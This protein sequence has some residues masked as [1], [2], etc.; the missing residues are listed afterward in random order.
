VL[1]AAVVVLIDQLTKLL[2]L[3]YLGAQGGIH[4][5]GNWLVL[6]VG[7]NTGAAFS[8]LTGH[9]P[10]FVVIA[11]AA[12]VVMA[13][14]YSRTSWRQPYAKIGLA[15]AFGGAL[16][17]LIDRV[18]LGYVVDF[19]S[20]SVWPIFNVADTAIVTGVGFV[21]LNLWVAERRR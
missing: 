18:R 20:V 2:A 11:S 15:L 21:I 10:V 5:I 7:K 3:R 8:F 1:I 17:N 13:Y 14:Y 6:T 16:G 4:V 12:C 19:I 9:S